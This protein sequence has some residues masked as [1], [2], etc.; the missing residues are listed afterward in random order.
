MANDKF[1]I[2]NNVLIKYNGKDTVVNVPEGVEVIGSE[3]FIY[4]EK[5]KEVALPKSCTII[6]KN[7][8]YYCEKLNRVTMNGDVTKIDKGAFGLCSKLEYINIPDSVEFI[9]NAAI[10]VGKIKELHLPKS[11]GNI[12]KANFLD[13]GYNEFTLTSITIDNDNPNLATEDGVLYNKDKTVLYKYPPNKA[14][15]NFIVPETVKVIKDR[16]FEKAINLKSIVLPKNIIEI[17]NSAF[18]SCKNLEKINF[19]EGLKIIGSVAFYETAITEANL[20]QGLKEINFDAFRRCSQ[21]KTVNIPGSV[22]KIGNSIFEDCRNLETIIIG[23]GISKIDFLE[24][25]MF[26]VP[27]LISIPASVT[28][29]KGLCSAE[30]VIID[31]KNEHYVVED[32]VLYNKDK[33]ELIRCLNVQDRKIYKAPD[34][35]KKIRPH[36]FW[37]D[38]SAERVILPEGFTRIED[39]GFTAAKGLVTVELPSTLEYIGRVAFQAS[40]IEYLDIP[41]NTVIGV[42]ENCLGELRSDLFS[43]CKNLKRVTLPSTMTCIPEFTFNECGNLEEIILPETIKSI[44]GYAFTYCN[45]LKEVVIPSNCEIL[46]SHAFAYCS[47]LTKIVIPPSVKS[48]DTSTSYDG[49]FYEC[50]NLTIYGESGSYIEKAA[51]LAEIPFEPILNGEME[52]IGDF[53]VQDGQLVAYTGN[54]RVIEIPEQVKGILS[55]VFANVILKKVIMHNEVK[56]I[57]A[58]AFG[59]NKNFIIVGEFGSNAYNFALEN[60]IFFRETKKDKVIDS[61]LEFEIEDGNLISY[62]YNHRLILIPDEVEYIAYRAFFNYYIDVLRFG[63]NLKG[64]SAG[65]FLPNCKINSIAYTGSYKDIKGIKDVGLLNL[66]L[67]NDTYINVNDPS[68]RYRIIP[69]NTEMFKT[70]GMGKYLVVDR[71]SMGTDGLRQ[72]IKDKK[73]ENVGKFKTRFSFENGKQGFIFECSHKKLDKKIIDFLISKK[74]SMVFDDMI[75]AFNPYVNDNDLNN[76]VHGITGDY[77]YLIKQNHK[78]GVLS[79]RKYVNDQFDLISTKVN[80]IEKSFFNNL[81]YWKADYNGNVSKW[82][83]IEG[84]SEISKYIKQGYVRCK[85]A[86]VQYINISHE[87]APKE[88]ILYYG[89]AHLGY[90]SRIQVAKAGGTGKYWDFIYSMQACVFESEMI[91]DDTAWC[92]DEE[93]DMVDY[94]VYDYD[95][96]KKTLFDV[97]AG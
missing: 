16:A 54:D 70:K 26:C 48:I 79:E 7:A 44:S 90:K 9:G 97:E 80:K 33:T 62:N 85:D 63:K 29:I 58:T 27:K 64:I 8:F 72:L 46:D 96:F 2:E 15:E 49:T 28:E 69:P 4:N 61:L 25:T 92:E 21:L 37:L 24:S 94:S 56:S 14:G 5:I 68:K 82:L 23:E 18:S 74:I 22:E 66:I 41:K 87:K 83:N 50:N 76:N 59:K 11:L 81:D 43:N 39:Y 32:G 30:N 95:N 73:S 65:A 35:L 20:P 84:Q 53:L 91:M 3:V 51:K 93:G 31:P 47:N 17:A 89:Y 12:E 42:E 78:N 86:V 36:A 67:N 6:E 77:P 57:S 40:S 88:K 13:F 34:T 60:R 71:L 38:K 75:I 1:I 45:S 55:D 19:P 52:K 10:S